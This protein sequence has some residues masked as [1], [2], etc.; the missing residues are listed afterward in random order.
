ME[1]VRGLKQVKSSCLATTSG[2]TGNVVQVRRDFGSKLNSFSR[3]SKQASDKQIKP[4]VR[5]S[6]R[7]I[8]GIKITV[9]PVKNMHM[10]MKQLP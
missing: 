9:V 1:L 2:S 10:I 5:K 4:E 8:L 6:G 3:R 7:C